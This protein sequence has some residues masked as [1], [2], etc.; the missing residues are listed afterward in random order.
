MTSVQ[1]PPPPAPVPAA[2]AAAPLPADAVPV[3]AT[4]TYLPP[5]LE[6]TDRA[7]TLKGEVIAANPDGTARI[8]TPRGPIDVQLPPNQLA[9]KGQIVEVQLPAGSP[10][11]AIKVTLPPTTGTNTAPPATALPATATPAAPAITAPAQA[12]APTT[13]NSIAAAT[14]SAAPP[15]AIQ[16]ALQAVRGLLPSLLNPTPQTGASLPTSN[17]IGPQELTNFLK[18]SLQ[19][20]TKTP[21][22]GVGNAAQLKAFAQNPLQTGQMVRLTPTITMP[23]ITAAPAL[24]NPTPT[25]LQ[26][27]PL[28]ATLAPTIAATATPHTQA[29][30]Q[31]FLAP[32]VTPAPTLQA[33]LKTALLATPDAQIS[34]GGIPRIAIETAPA[35]PA[36][37]ILQP[38][39]PAIQNAAQPNTVPVTTIATPPAL[40]MLAAPDAAAAPTAIRIPVMTMQQTAPQLPNP[41]DVRVSAIMPAIQNAQHMVPQP[42]SMANLLHGTP[43]TPTIFATFTGTT[44]QGLP[45]VELPT[46]SIAA[47]GIETPAPTPM[48]MQYPARGLAP[49]SIM[50]LDILPAMTGA[51]SA[52]SATAQPAITWEALDDALQSLRADPQTA[53]HAQALQAALPKVAGGVAFTAPALIYAAAL[54]GSDINQWLGEK[55]IDGIKSAKRGDL[56]ARIGSDFAAASS[57]RADDAAT[58]NKGEWRS[59]TLPMLYGAHIQTIQMH[60]RA[61]ERDDPN[62]ADGKKTGTRFVMDL[63]LTRMGPMQ[64]DGFSVDKRLDVTLRS[65]QALSAPMREM[66]RARYSSAMEG[67]GFAGQLN[68]S[69]TPEK[70]GWVVIEELQK[71]SASVRA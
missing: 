60:T 56:L 71:R 7:L 49:A 58:T 21:E 66:M 29:A 11:T 36:L 64:I 51:T 33:T 3:P 61:F 65:E 46:F 50:K 55:T 24:Q 68:F 17:N 48:V 57:D 16:A 1:P 2:T 34:L 41:M 69:A 39:T 9:V 25:A 10:P 18:A 19:N 27:T 15:N 43:I 52:L 37:R 59:L 47:D 23:S 35:N 20:I 45:M 40:G 13:Q 44:Q 22:T 26:A 28:Q 32:A 6:V 38:F 42:A 67:I 14:P 54:K 12:A 63:S 53:P 5:S 8:A 62:A 4:A 30:L 31:S 70:R